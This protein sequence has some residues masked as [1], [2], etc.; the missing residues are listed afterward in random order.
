MTDCLV[1]A[2]EKKMLT[3]T[4]LLP[5]SFLLGMMILTAVTA[6]ADDYPLPI[7]VEEIVIPQTKDI[8]DFV[9]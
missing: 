7:T 5:L 8:K 1:K 3:R 4:T 2:L 6:Q 9:G